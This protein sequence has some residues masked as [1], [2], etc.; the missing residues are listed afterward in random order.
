MSIPRMVRWIWMI[1]RQAHERTKFVSDSC[2]NALWLIHQGACPVGSLCKERFGGRWVNPSCTW[3]LMQIWCRLFRLFQGIRWSDGYRR[4]L[5]WR[6]A[7]EQM[8]PVEFGGEMIDFAQSKK[9]TWKELPWKFEAGTPNMAGA[10]RRLLVWKILGMGC[11][12]PA[13]ADLIAYVFPLQA[14]GWGLTIYGSQDLAQR[15]GGLP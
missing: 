7:G 5:R 10:I 2:S 1:S 15:S 9:Q 13:W 4:S 6:I 14:V 8:S 11:H 12:C 3:R